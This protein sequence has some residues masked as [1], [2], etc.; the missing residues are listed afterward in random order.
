LI[1]KKRKEERKRDLDKVDETVTEKLTRERR[2]G[3]MR[4]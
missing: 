1:E 3:K 4:K 2:N